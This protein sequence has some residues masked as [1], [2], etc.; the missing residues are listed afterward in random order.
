[1][2][3]ASAYV[4]MRIVRERER[5]TDYYKGL[6]HECS[7]VQIFFSFIIRQWLAIALYDANGDAVVLQIVKR[8]WQSC[9]AQCITIYSTHYTHALTMHGQLNGRS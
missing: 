8:R 2:N 5:D 9:T 3:C 1:M 6:L 4:A 7:D